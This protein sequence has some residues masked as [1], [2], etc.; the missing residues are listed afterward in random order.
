M[1]LSAFPIAA[2]NRVLEDEVYERR[3]REDLFYRINVVKIDVPPLRERGGDVL[4]LARHF[5]KIYAER[6]GKHETMEEVS[7]REMNWR[8]AEMQRQLRN[9]IEKRAVGMRD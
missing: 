4:H 7:Y 5:L 8:A 1:F 6:H 2:T 9:L 3:F